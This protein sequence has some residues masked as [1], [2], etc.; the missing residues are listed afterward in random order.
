MAEATVVP[1]HEVD[2]WSLPDSLRSPSL[3]GLFA[4]LRPPL[5]LLPRMTSLRGGQ[6]KHEI[7]L[8]VQ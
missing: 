2:M 5:P 4:T 7:L 8:L 6:A 3:R 1:I